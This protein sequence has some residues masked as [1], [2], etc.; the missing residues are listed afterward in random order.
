MHHVTRRIVLTL[1]AALAAA[2]VATP[3]RSQPLTWDTLDARLDDAAASGVN[4]V[5]LVVRDDRIVVHRAMG[6]ANRELDIPMS[7]G[8][9]FAI[10]STPI[11]FTRAGI[12]LLAEQ[13]RLRL[14]DP[15]T[16]FL[17]Q[18]PPDKR[19]ITIEHLMDGASGLPDFHDL[20]GDADP[21]HTWIDRDEA[22]RRILAQPLLFEPGTD[23]RHSHSA[24][25][26]LAAIIEIASTQSYPEFTRRHLLE[27]AGMRDT[28]FFGEPLAD[29]R[30]A[31][32]YGT[33]RDGTV[34]APP[35]WGPTSW[36]V[37]GSGG[38]TSTAGDMLRWHRA[39]RN[40]LILNPE[41]L[42]RYFAMPG[43]VMNGGD[44]YGFEILYTQGPGTMAIMLTND[45]TPAALDAWR[46]VAESIIDLVL[47]DSR[48]PFSL[49]IALDVRPTGVVIADVAPDGAAA[50]GGLEPGDLIRTINGDAVDGRI[51]STLDPALRRGDPI[52]FVVERDGATRTIVVTPRSRTR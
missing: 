15:I 3:T 12:L 52:E 29:T 27:P 47:D 2:S 50:E 30:T 13:G 4:G 20:P 44:A 28:G 36:L 8:T 35:Y 39:L 37:M 26:L 33:R 41:S 24:W 48:P 17:D 5:F 7:T 14:T 34:N 9:I 11:D 40:G 51:M 46:D 45:N 1:L 31:I 32:G 43:A 22:V 10:G 23:E 25:G 38:Q 16:R 6:R 18:V 49:G 19:T 42:D 21:D